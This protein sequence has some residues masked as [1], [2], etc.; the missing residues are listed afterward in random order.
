MLINTD[1]CS[2]IDY[3]SKQQNNEKRFNSHTQTSI[4]RGYD[5]YYYYFIEC[6]GEA[7]DNILLSCSVFTH[8]I[9]TVALHVC[10]CVYLIYDPVSVGMSYSNMTG[11]VLLYSPDLFTCTVKVYR[12]CI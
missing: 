6:L 12:G 11:S 5:N 2:Y 4:H 3:I 10:V 1:S 9:R 8:S 7:D